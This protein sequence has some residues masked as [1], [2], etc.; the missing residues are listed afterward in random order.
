MFS[1]FGK[2]HEKWPQIGQK[3][4]FFRAAKKKLISTLRDTSFGAILR[5]FWG[6]KKKFLAEKKTC[7]KKYMCV[8]ETKTHVRRVSG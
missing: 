2:N 6:S 3:I 8:H 5:D 4:E 7:R 1:F